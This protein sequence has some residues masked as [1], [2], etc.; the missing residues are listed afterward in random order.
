MNRIVFSPTGSEAAALFL[1]ECSR[2]AEAGHEV[3]VTIVSAGEGSPI[4]SEAELEK[5]APDG[6]EASL[7]FANLSGIVELSPSDMLIRAKGGTPVSGIALAADESNLWFPHYDSSIDVEM[8]IADLLMKAP[9]LPVSEVRGGLREYVLSVELVTGCGEVVRFG[10]RSIKDVAGYEVIGLLL[11]GGGR[12]GMI[13]E[14]TLRLIP[15]PAGRQTDSIDPDLPDSMMETD[16]G[17]IERITA[18]V[19]KV[20][21][22]AGILRW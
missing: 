22:P 7:S 19:Q 13:T 8:S 1:A 3:S 10:S 4:E 11:G 16:S 18:D 14:A 9:R 6:I 15:P 12:Y 5:L 20:F 2:L 21:D 17:P